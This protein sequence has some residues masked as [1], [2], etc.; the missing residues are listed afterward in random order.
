V[1]DGA[2]TDGTVDWLASCDLPD[3]RYISEK[4]AGLY[5]AM[6]R[7]IEVMRNEVEYIIF[8]NSGDYFHGEDVL[9]RAGRAL[10]SLAVK[11]MLLYGDSVE[12]FG[13]G[14]SF[15]RKA[16]KPSWITIGMFTH[17]QAAFFYVSDQ[18]YYDIRLRL[19]A[20]YE[21]FFR[22]VRTYGESACRYLAFPVCDFSL[23]GLSHT[24]RRKAILEEFV[25]RQKHGVSRPV[26]CMLVCLHYIAHFLKVVAPGSIRLFGLRKR[27][28]KDTQV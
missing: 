23:G 14:V 20:D 2:S 15:Y 6:N 27:I 4:D 3:F 9:E 12:R 16:R 11:P 24:K 21:L 8:L 28:D 10:D 1:V 17:H 18:L 19:A 26:N 25:L 5:H 13:D 22:Y 7:G